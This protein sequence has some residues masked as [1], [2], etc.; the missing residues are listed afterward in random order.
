MAPI[1]HFRFYYILAGI[2]CLAVSLILIR[3]GVGSL[4]AA[5]RR[6]AK[7]AVL[8]ARGEY[9]QP[10]EV[11]SQDEIGQLTLSFNDMVAGLKS[12][13]S[14]AIRSAVTWT[15]ILPPSSWSGRKPAVWAEKN[16]RWSSC[17][18]T[19]GVLPPLPRP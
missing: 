7:K 6:I 1:L 11:H 18:P 19:S 13:I 16:G 14:S 4:V 12:G 17:S 3:L 15:R 5:I 8:V 9:G 10:L 2:L